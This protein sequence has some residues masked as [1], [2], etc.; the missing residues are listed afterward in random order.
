[1]VDQFWVVFK[2]A[3]NSG[4]VFY[5]KHIFDA[6]LI[7]NSCVH[8][9]GLVFMLNVYGFYHSLL[10]SVGVNCLKSVMLNDNESMIIF[11]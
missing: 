11:A 4:C 7:S 8:I 9:E 5:D 1:M 10:Q 2:I 6:C 3:L